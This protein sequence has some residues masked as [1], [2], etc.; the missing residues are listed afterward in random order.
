MGAPGT[1]VTIRGSG[2]LNGATV[3]LGTTQETATFVDSNTLQ[4]TVPQIANGTVRV[5]VTN[6]GDQQYSFD[7]AFTVN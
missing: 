3:T 4:V 5:T 1:Q 7:D 2:F 6:P